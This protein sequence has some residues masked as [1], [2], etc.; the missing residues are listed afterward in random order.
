MSLNPL[1][2]GREFNAGLLKPKG[3]VLTYRYGNGMALF[4]MLGVEVDIRLCFFN[5]G[6]SDS[7]ESFLCDFFFLYLFIFF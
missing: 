6:G 3:E 1:G 4:Q 7:A 5:S 2:E